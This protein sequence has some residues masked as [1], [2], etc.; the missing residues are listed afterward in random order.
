MRERWEQILRILCLVL[1]ALLIYR[2][3]MVV[4]RGPLTGLNIPAVP[5]L[6]ETNVVA[7]GTGT[8]APARQ[9]ANKGTNGTNAITVAAAS[10]T[11][12][13]N[14][15]KASVVTA[16]DTNGPA[17]N[18]PAK[19]DT[20]VAIVA[21]PS[22]TNSITNTAAIKGTNGI[23]GAAKNGTNDLAAARGKSGTNGAPRMVASGNVPPGFPGG[24]GMPGGPNKAPELP[25]LIQGRINKIIVSEMFAQLMRPQPPELMGIAGNY[26]F[27]RASSGQTGIVKEG[28]SLGGLKLLEVGINR[29]LI[30][31]DGEKKELMIYAG[32]GSESL[33]TK[34][35]ENT[36]DIAK[37][38]P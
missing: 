7:S 32:L 19:T 31:E 37:K 30:E 1:I 29:A 25:P 8:N 36:N 9:T 21:I 15:G 14:A 12:L 18:K 24:P 28:D 23:A 22:G 35:K 38:L 6:V 11:N 16:S 2:V 10:G 26:A 4:K 27:L 3:C 17:T 33:M 5:R 13:T 34:P 20:N